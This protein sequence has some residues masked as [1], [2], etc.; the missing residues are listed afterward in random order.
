[1]PDGKRGTAVQPSF[2]AHSLAFASEMMYRKQSVKMETYPSYSVDF[3]G[4]HIFCAGDIDQDTAV[5][6]VIIRH[7]LTVGSSNEGLASMLLHVHPGGVTVEDAEQA[8]WVTETVVAEVTVTVDGGIVG[9]VVGGVLEAVV[10]M[11]SQALVNF[12]A[13]D[14]QALAKAG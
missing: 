1:M 14:E 10:A 11:H 2:S 6:S 8:V 3:T 4:L 12:A 5:S 7:G 9:H 13:D